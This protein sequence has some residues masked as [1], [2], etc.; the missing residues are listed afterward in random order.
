M[1]KKLPS[2]IMIEGECQHSG[3]WVCGRL[4]RQKFDLGNN[5]NTKRRFYSGIS[6]S[7]RNWKTTLKKKYFN[8]ISYYSG[9]AA[10]LSR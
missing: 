9:A 8:P 3:K 10:A 5:G 6:H 2:L 4:Y 7:W 1:G